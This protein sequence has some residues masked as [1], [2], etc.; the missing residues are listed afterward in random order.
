MQLLPYF[1]QFGSFLGFAGITLQ[2]PEFLSIK[3]RGQMQ[4]GFNDKCAFS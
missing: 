2:L 1:I 3:G 4:Q